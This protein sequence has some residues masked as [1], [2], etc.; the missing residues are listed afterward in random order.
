MK[1][2]RSDYQQYLIALFF[3]NL[4]LWGQIYMEAHLRV[5]IRLFICVMSNMR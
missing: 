2:R 4:S 5:M 1:K 3:G